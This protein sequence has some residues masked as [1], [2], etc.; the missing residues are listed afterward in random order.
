MGRGRGPPPAMELRTKRGPTPA[1]SVVSCFAG[2]LG[3]D[4]MM[5]LLFETPSGFAI[6][7]IDGTYLSPP[8]AMENIWAMFA[9]EYSAQ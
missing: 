8:D 6:L 4:G 9:K 1:R 5:L 3:I 2:K 7:Y